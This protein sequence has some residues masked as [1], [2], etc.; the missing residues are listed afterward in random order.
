[1]YGLINIFGDDFMACD[2][3]PRLN[4]F[5][6][7]FGIPRE[8]NADRDLR[9]VDICTPNVLLI[10]PFQ[11]PSLNIPWPNAT[12]NPN[13]NCR[14]IYDIPAGLA[15]TNCFFRITCADEELICE[16][17]VPSINVNVAGE[18]ILVFDVN[19]TP[20]TWVGAI[21]LINRTL[22]AA[23]RWYRTDT[24]NEITNVRFAEFIRLIDGS[25]IVAMTN[26]EIDIENQQIIL[27]A[28][29]VEKLWK[30]ENV[31]VTGVT[32]YQQ[33]I[34]AQPPVVENITV[35]DTFGEHAIPPC[36]AP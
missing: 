33:L 36:T 22:T 21:P 11:L 4:G 13:R 12:T 15:P 23:S 25:C 28:N 27:T 20:V 19:G 24:G 34:L 2:L 5:S 30:Y 29:I 10:H 26:C 7:Q 32:P 1:M 6:E 18:L 17:G 31:W 16:N 14:G 3:I 35:P 9:C 8:L